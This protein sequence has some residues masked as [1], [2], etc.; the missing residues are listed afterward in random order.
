MNAASCEM[1]AVPAL[2]LA[3][4]LTAVGC[5][6]TGTDTAQDSAAW[7]A[8][9]VEV[10]ML[11]GSYGWQIFN[12]E[13]LV[14]H[15][16]VQGVWPTVIFMH[17][18]SGGDP[19]PLSKALVR[20]GFAVI[21]P[22]SLARPSYDGSCIPERHIY[23]TRR[24]AVAIRTADLTHAI[25]QAK[26]LP[27]VDARNLFLVGQSEGGAIVARFDSSGPKH[28]VTA[29]VIGGDNCSWGGFNAPRSEPVLAVLG[30][31]DPVFE[32]QGGFNGSC[33]R[34]M[35]SDNGSRNVLYTTGTASTMH[36]QLTHYPP[37]IS[38]LSSCA[39]TRSGERVKRRSRA[40]IPTV[41][42]T[43]AGPVEADSFADAEECAAQDVGRSAALQES[44][45]S[46]H[47]CAEPTHRHQRPGIRGR[48][49]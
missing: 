32:S 6:T 44:L 18:C 36:A 26:R 40:A 30:N 15:E 22:N 46:A 35:H 12:K 27:W 3:L 19:G 1:K 48:A 4:A 2:V 10:P 41:F 13:H 39:S 11:D 16:D 49:R 20:A 9:M 42:V 38:C 47:G 29:R 45:N 8:A 24:D 43:L 7:N 17:G 31:K 23:G 5:K 14:P 33:G 37:G 21:T 25:E 28:S 34:F